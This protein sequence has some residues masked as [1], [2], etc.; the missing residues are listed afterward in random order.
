MKQTFPRT[1]KPSI[2]LSS[3]I[4]VLCDYLVGK[5]IMTFA[6]II[7]SFLQMR[8]LDL[9]VSTG[10]L[11]EPPPTDGVNLVHEDDARLVVPG[12]V[13]HLPDQ[14]GR[15][16]NVLVHDCARDDFEEVCIELAGHCSRQQGLSC[17][18]R[19]VQQAAWI[20]KVVEAV[21]RL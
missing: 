7:V 13:E 6:N 15:L 12:I 10:A 2:W 1:S 18:W 11:A 8:Y 21:L 19:P 20:M 5:L 14:P 3:S 9:S 4:S 17:S 16:S